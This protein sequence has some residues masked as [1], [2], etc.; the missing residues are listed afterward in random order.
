VCVS[1]SEY[2]DS[3]CTVIVTVSGNVLL[4]YNYLSVLLDY[5]SYCQCYCTVTVTVAVPACLHFM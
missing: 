4:L 1:V 3:Y 2:Y 5:Y